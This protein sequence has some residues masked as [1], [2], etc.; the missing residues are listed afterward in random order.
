MLL[1]V[2]DLSVVR[3]HRTLGHMEP[4]TWHVGD[5]VKKLREKKGW[6][7]TELAKEARVHKNTVA[8]IED[9]SEGAK[10]N[11]LKKIAVALDTTLAKIYQLVPTT[12]EETQRA[13]PDATAG[14][15]FPKAGHQ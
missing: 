5:V 6:S 11:T 7:Q 2:K 9:G 3:N 12:N 14:Q 13:T 1:S 8:R 4:L 15:P 10:S